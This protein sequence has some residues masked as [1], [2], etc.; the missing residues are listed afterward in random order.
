MPDHREKSLADIRAKNDALR[1]KVSQQE[2][3]QEQ[4]EQIKKDSLTWREK[5]AD[6]ETQKQGTQKQIEELMKEIDEK[7][8]NIDRLIV[9]YHEILLSLQLIPSTSPLANGVDYKLVLEHVEDTTS[10]T[11]RNAQQYQ[12]QIVCS[13][14][15]SKLEV[16]LKPSVEK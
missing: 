7:A 9:T 13:Q 16:V 1:L 8:T 6:V 15:L 2:L 3:S 12:K 5:I 11:I 14:M 4:V 10:A